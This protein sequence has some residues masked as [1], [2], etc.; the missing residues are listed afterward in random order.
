MFH[1]TV[2]RGFIQYIRVLHGSTSV[3]C[4]TGSC[5][6]SQVSHYI[7]LSQVSYARKTDWVW[8]GQTLKDGAWRD[9]NG[10][11]VR[12]SSWEPGQPD[13]RSSNGKYQTSIRLGKHGQWDDT[14][15]DKKHPFICTHTGN[16]LSLILV[17]SSLTPPSLFP[18]ALHLT[19]P[20]LSP[21]ALHLTPPTLSL[22]EHFI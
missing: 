13:S 21:R 22:L 7:P 16:I 11:E 17:K 3:V 18:T 1:F 12:Y 9:H 20:S 14:F 6:T 19:P 5:C 8:L 10:D 4:D 15:D 2:C